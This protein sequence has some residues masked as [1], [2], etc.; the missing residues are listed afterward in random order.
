MASF[1][2]KIEKACKD[3]EIPGAVL[4]AESADGMLPRIPSISFPLPTQSARGD[5]TDGLS[6]HS[7][8]SKSAYS[9]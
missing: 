7:L 5:S 4:I 9:P 2:H 8:N 3:L 1:E 6:W